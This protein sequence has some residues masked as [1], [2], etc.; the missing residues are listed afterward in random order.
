MTAPLVLAD[1]LAAGVAGDAALDARMWAPF[2]PGVAASWV[3]ANGDSGPASA[4][5]KYEPGAAI[6]WHWHPAYE[7]ILVLRGS[8]SDENGLYRAGSVLVSPPGTG[9]TVRS[10]EGCLVLAVWEKPVRFDPPAG[11]PAAGGQDR[12]V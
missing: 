3:Y 5:L 2:R 12:A 9:H 7:H 4:F 11:R 1:I 6:P 8:Q 10:D